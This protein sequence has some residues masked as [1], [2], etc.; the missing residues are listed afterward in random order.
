MRIPTLFIPEDRNIDINLEKILAQK[1]YYIPKDWMS[2]EVCTVNGDFVTSKTLDDSKIKDEDL[3]SIRKLDKRVTDL[4]IF[5]LNG[6]DMFITKFGDSMHNLV[7][8]NDKLEELLFTQSYPNPSYCVFERKKDADVLVMNT[9]NKD[10]SCGAKLSY[11]NNKGKEV[12]SFYAKISHEAGYG[13]D[14]LTSVSSL[15]KTG[16][17]NYLALH[18]FNH[19]AVVD[20]NLS[21]VSSFPTPSRSSQNISVVDIRGKENIL[22]L[23]WKEHKQGYDYHTQVLNVFDNKFSL[24]EQLDAKRFGCGF[25]L[26]CKNVK[27]NG[28]E[29]L[30]FM[31]QNKD[32]AD[33]KI[34][35]TRFEE[36]F[37]VKDVTDCWRIRVGKFNDKNYVFI[38]SGPAS[39]EKIRIYDEGFK[40]KDELAVDNCSLE[41]LYYV[42]NIKGIDYLA[43]IQEGRLNFYPGDFPL[44]GSFFKRKKPVSIELRKDPNNM[45]AYHL[46]NIIPFKHKDEDFLAL[47]YWHNECTDIYD[48]SF[49][50]VNSFPGGD[51][52][53]A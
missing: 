37:D 30:F 1:V 13:Y 20:E 52:C 15:V 43:L 36:V 47:E 16:K 7:V 50:L 12:G 4:N 26:M 6:K 10:N 28:K 3:R 45:W 14:T 11:Y 22:A 51:F 41:G 49:K 48:R 44:K 25:V 38:P 27:F 39:K 31:D 9:S 35:D 46:K 17:Q 33:L 53:I 23:G 40:L 2:I 19:I 42:V 8:F 29:L 24:V 32:Y 18:Y 21:I 5:K 34:F